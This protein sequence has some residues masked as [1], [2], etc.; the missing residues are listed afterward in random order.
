MNA[1]KA[2]KGSTM[3]P[4]KKTSRINI[5]SGAEYL[6][7][8]NDGRRVVV[9]GEL[10]DDTATHP[11]TRDYAHAVAGCYDAHRD[12]ANYELM[13]FVGDD[14]VRRAMMWMRQGDKAGLVRRRQYHDRMYRFSVIRC[15]AAYRTLTMVCS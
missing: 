10:I 11:L 7:S 2:T 4:A 12:P 1:S 9:N 8:L 6:A 14:G 5:R 13:T 3:P 15:S